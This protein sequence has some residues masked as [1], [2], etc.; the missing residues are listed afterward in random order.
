MVEY[1]DTRKGIAC[2]GTQFLSDFVDGLAYGYLA[3]KKNENI[4]EAENSE[5]AKKSMILTKPVLDFLNDFMDRLIDS[6]IS[7]VNN[8]FT[9]N[10]SEIQITRD[11]IKK[12]ARRSNERLLRTRE[13]VRET[14]KDFIAYN[15]DLFGSPKQ[16]SL[17]IQE[18][19]SLSDE[20][21]KT[22]TDKIFS[23]I[24]WAT[25]FYYADE[26]KLLPYGKYTKNRM[27][28]FIVT[29]GIGTTFSNLKT[30]YYEAMK[31]IN[32]KMDYPINKLE[33][34]I[35]FI[36]ENYNQA[37]TKV[38]NDIIFLKENRID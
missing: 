28:L 4:V 24:E 22:K 36:K 1:V 9:V 23:V 5:E 2:L 25:I 16:E 13:D 17:T 30:S 7:A 20:E 15:R 29:H 10:G 8:K 19:A 38:E 33:L 37:V 3:H 35:P 12:Q 27:E 32:E 34:I 11:E 31:R 21:K 18:P 6:E 26:T 14:I